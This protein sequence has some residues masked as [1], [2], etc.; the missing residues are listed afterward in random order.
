MHERTVFVFLALATVL[1]FTNPVVAQQAFDLDAG[2]VVLKGYHDLLLLPLVEVGITGEQ[3]G[4]Y[5]RGVGFN[6]GGAGLGLQVSIYSMRHLFSLSPWLSWQLDHGLA[7]TSIFND[8]KRILYMQGPTAALQLS[9]KPFQRLSW[10]ITAEVRHIH[11]VH[12]GYYGKVWF[13]NMFVG[14]GTSVAF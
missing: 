13:K 6:Q 5:Y 9:L 8:G 10:K 3:V 14:L 1:S 4:L 11:M 12:Y 2:L 7:V